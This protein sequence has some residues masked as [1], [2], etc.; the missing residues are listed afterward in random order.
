[1]ATTK[2][3]YTG[4][5]STTVYAVPFP[6]LSASDLYVTVAG[7]VST[8]YTPTG[9]NGSTGSLTFNTAPANGAAIL[10]ERR[11][12]IE[13]PRVDFTSTA[14]LTES[15]LDSAVGQ[16][17]FRQQ[18]QEN[19]VSQLSTDLANAVL[20]SGNLPTPQSQGQMLAVSAGLA[21][22]RYTPNQIVQTVLKSELDSW[23]AAI[24]HAA[25]TM[26]TA[27]LTFSANTGNPGYVANDSNTVWTTRCL[28]N[29]DN[30]GGLTVALNS[31]I[32]VSASS[33]ST[34]TV[35]GATTNGVAGGVSAVFQNFRPPAGSYRFEARARFGFTIGDVRI[36]LM[37]V[38]TS[39]PL[40]AGPTLDSTFA[41]TGGGA[42]SGG[43]ASVS[44]AFVANGSEDF[45]LAY[46]CSSPGTNTTANG[47]GI[48]AVTPQTQFGVDEPFVEI[49]LTKIA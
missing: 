40:V 4:N 25:T 36:A 46:R 6:F 47:L 48:L 29:A 27:R 1:M 26:P 22:T 21:W 9:G 18:E 30:T 38:G 15:D 45:R 42:G 44:G 37:K 3:N 13:T 19:A 10:I 35:K 7:L 24:V 28:T 2:V 39:T 8:S 20:S 33:A 43:I 31:A 41:T 34:G 12:N 11:T 16:V 23:H 17:L 32:S 5:G 14:T 49:V